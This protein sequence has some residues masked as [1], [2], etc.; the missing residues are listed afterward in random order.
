MKGIQKLQDQYNKQF[1]KLKLQV[2]IQI[3]NI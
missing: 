3:V 2:N 1:E